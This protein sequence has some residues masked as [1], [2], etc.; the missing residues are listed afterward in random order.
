MTRRVF[1]RGS[2]HCCL[3]PRHPRDREPNM[4]RRLIS[5]AYILPTFPSPSLPAEGTGGLSGLAGDCFPGSSCHR[6]R[7]GGTAPTIEASKMM[8]MM[9][10]QS[11]GMELERSQGRS[12]ALSMRTTVSA[13][14]DRVCARCRPFLLTDEYEDDG[15]APQKPARSV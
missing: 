7:A 6:S 3:I 2:L 15:V 5:S 14:L 13:S 10:C 11:N 4:R 1:L 12:R 8:H 9:S